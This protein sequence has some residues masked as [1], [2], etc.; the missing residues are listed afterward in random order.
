MRILIVFPV[1]IAFGIATL[2]WCIARNLNLERLYAI[3]SVVAFV[4]SLIFLKHTMTSADVHVAENFMHNH[5]PHTAVDE[6]ATTSDF[7]S[8][9]DVAT[10]DSEIDTDNEAESIFE[11]DEVIRETSSIIFDGECFYTEEE[12]YSIEEGSG[13]ARAVDKKLNINGNEVWFQYIWEPLDGGVSIAIGSS[14]TGEIHPILAEQ[15]S[16]NE[17]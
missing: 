13:N 2:L 16:L 8:N 1:L 12:F 3:V 4:I 15:L 10:N 5:S 9:S 11:T 14:S 6:N 17:E 7:E